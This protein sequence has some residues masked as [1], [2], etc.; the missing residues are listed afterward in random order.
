[1][2]SDAEEIHAEE[3]ITDL[4]AVDTEHVVE[5][6]LAAL[7]LCMQTQLHVSKSASQHII[8]SVNDILAISNVNTCHAIE[9]ILQKHGC[10]F[11]QSV[12]SDIGDALHNSNPFLSKTSEKGPLSTDYKRNLYFKSN[13]NV[14]ESVEYV[15]ERTK[16]QSFVYVPVLKTLKN[17]LSQPE[18]LEK[19]FPIQESTQGLYTSCFDGK[20][21]K[22]NA[23]LGGQNFKLSLGLYIDDFEVVN[24]LGTSRKK[25]KITAVYWVILNWSSEFRS[26]LNSIQLA[27]LGKSAEVK[28]YGYEAFFEPFLRD[29]KSLEK[30][31]VFVEQMGES[32]KGTVLTVSADN[33]GAH[34]VAGF[35]ESFH[36]E[37]FC[38]FCLASLN[39]IQTTAVS[40]GVKMLLRVVLSPN[41]IRKISISTPSSVEELVTVLCEKLQIERGFVLQY[42]DPDFN[43]ELCNLNDISEL[44]PDKAT[45]RLHWEV[46]LSAIPSDSDLSD[47]TLDT[48]SKSPSTRS[49][50]SDS[51]T[52]CDSDQVSSCMSR[53]DQWPSQF[54]IP[55]FSYDVELRLQKANEEFKNNGTHL[56]VTRDIKMHVLEK[57]AEAVYSYKAYPKDSELEKV[58]CALVD[59]NPCLKAPGSGGGWEGWKL[60][61][62]FKMANYRQK[63]RYAGCPEITVNFRQGSSRLSLKRPRRSELNFLPEHPVGFSEEALERDRAFM[64]EEVKKKDMKLSVLNSKMDVTFSLRRKEIVQDQPL[65]STVKQ[66]WPGLFI[67]E[68]VNI[69]FG[70]SVVNIWNIIMLNLSLSLSLSLSFCFSLSGVC[71]VSTH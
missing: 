4:E 10:S 31:G 50:T 55:S 32:V 43:Y 7:F 63:L 8:D 42:E 46:V 70:T 40:E 33:L 6:K 11:D 36:V 20:Y 28:M 53:S 44:P 65:V 25:H 41:D 39:D 66:R 5:H 48:A 49:S 2:Q 26:G 13:F 34:G 61:L 21:F 35:Q 71:R 59:K 38:R 19:T 51:A 24:P 16:K 67:E 29:L 68:Q 37:K 56:N 12:V 69:F 22:E 30:D 23:L 52:A 47:F 62:K 3:G 27:L 15:F 54:P 57:L 60:S 9:E 45:L 64:E 1:M 18:V 17:L 58:A 14:I